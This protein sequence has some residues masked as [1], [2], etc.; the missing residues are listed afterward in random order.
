MNERF[1]LWGCVLSLIIR[2]NKV[3]MILRKNKP[4]A[5]NYN[6]VGG[7][8]EENETVSMAIIREIKEEVG[9]DATNANI[10]V[11]GS[12][13]RV[14]KDGWN[15]IEYVVAIRNLQ[16]EPVNLEPQ[17]CERLEWI[18]LDNLPENITPYARCAIENYIN[19]II[20]SEVNS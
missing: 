19:G 2:D 10:D 13:H 9:L 1:K 18:P 12:L 7:R 17:V 16:G 15:S 3:L 14:C 6:L 11:V 8:M 4:D 5:G 20:F